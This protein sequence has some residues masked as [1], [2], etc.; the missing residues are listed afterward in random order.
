MLFKW[1]NPKMVTSRSGSLTKNAPMVFR[2]QVFILSA[3]F[4]KNMLRCK[5]I[6]VCIWLWR[7]QTEITS[8]ASKFSFTE[9]T[10]SFFVIRAGQKIVI[11]RLDICVNFTL[12]LNHWADVWNKPESVTCQPWKNITLTANSR[13][14]HTRC[15]ALLFSNKHTTTLSAVLVDCVKSWSHNLLTNFIPAD[16]QK[17]PRLC[18]S[19]VQYHF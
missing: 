11:M 1:S 5:H 9:V 12:K 4:K 8:A 17:L 19:L 18:R 16:Q 7:S 3:S 10:S 13:W 14:S 2:W 15:T 6:A